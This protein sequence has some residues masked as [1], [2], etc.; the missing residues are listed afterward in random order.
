MASFM[1]QP[2]ILKGEEFYTEWRH[3]LQIWM[4]FTDLPK[5]KQGPVVFLSLPQKI[6]KCVRHL[7]IVDI[8]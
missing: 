8:S 4:L 5:E 1:K 2:T 7:L 6:C 3:D